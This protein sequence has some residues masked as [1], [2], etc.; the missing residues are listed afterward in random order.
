MNNIDLSSFNTDSKGELEKA[1]KKI[2]KKTGRKPK[3]DKDKYK[4]KVLTALTDKQKE[5]FTEALDG[6]SE[7]GVIRKLILEYIERQKI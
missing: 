4:H 2:P 6:R 7:A 3:A 1:S 5:D